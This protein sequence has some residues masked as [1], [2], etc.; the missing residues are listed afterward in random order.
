MAQHDIQHIGDS[1]NK[2]WGLSGKRYLFFD[3]VNDYIKFSNTLA[4]QNWGYWLNHSKDWS[5]CFTVKNYFNPFYN[6]IFWATENAFDENN[7]NRTSQPSL[8]V[9]SNW[10]LTSEVGTENVNSTNAY[11]YQY[12]NL[13]ASDKFCQIFV[14]FNTITKTVDFYQNGVYIN[15]IY[16]LL[17]Y[18][19]SHYRSLFNFQTVTIGTFFA[20]AILFANRFIQMDLL[21]FMVTN[22]YINNREVPHELYHAKLDRSK[23][24]TS[25]SANRLCDLAI[26][27]QTP[28]G[29]MIIPDLMGNT[30]ATIF[31]Q[32]TSDYRLIP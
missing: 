30:T 11:L 25:I 31:G 6:N 5:M 16:P 28:S 23:F 1:Q 26:D 8:E 22:N 10:L 7:F 3:G 32:A 24:P 21:Q 15:T 20:G 27:T 12:K 13:Y 19:N 17:F 9:T 4:G 14:S 2:N 18:W 29:S